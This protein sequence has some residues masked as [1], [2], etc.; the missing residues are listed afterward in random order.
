MHPKLAHIKLSSS[1]FSS[2]QDPKAIA[3]CGTFL[4]VCVCMRTYTRTHIHTNLH[5]YT[6]AHTNVHIPAHVH[7]CSPHMSRQVHTYTCIYVCTLTHTFTHVCSHMHTLADKGLV[8]GSLNSN[9][10]WGVAASMSAAV[11]LALFRGM[12]P[13][14]LGVES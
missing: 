14:G 11:A 12:K 4:C 13:F 7:T 1:F 3:I 9:A 2:G 6:R 5:M 10:T 8:H